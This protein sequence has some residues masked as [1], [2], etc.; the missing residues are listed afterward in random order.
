MEKKK[1]KKVWLVVFIIALLVFI[2]ALVTLLVMMIKGVGFFNHKLPDVISTDTEVTDTDTEDTRIENPVDFATLQG[3]NEDIYAWISMPYCDIEYPIIQPYEQDDLYYLRR[4]IYGEYE[5]S[6]TIFTEKLNT[7]TF[8]D[9]NTVIYGHNMLDGTMF[10][11]LLKFK[12]AEFFNANEYIYIYTPNMKYTYR[13]FAAYQYDDRHLLN[14]F[15]LNDEQ[16]RAYYFEEIQNPTSIFVNTRQVDLTLDSKIITL[17][18]CTGVNWESR[19][20]VQGV[21]ISSEE[22]RPKTE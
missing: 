17:S 1:S 11:N 19:Y 7:R 2:I 20:L 16:I 21:L 22:T 15:D 4:N 12:D 6:G 8:S 13:I 14:S 3:I 18:T 9:Y 5:F 10:S